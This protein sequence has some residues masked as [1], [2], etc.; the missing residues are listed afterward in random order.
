MVQRYTQ[1]KYGEAEPLLRRALKISKQAL[2]ENH[3]DVAQSLNTLAKVLC[4]EVIVAGVI[5]LDTAQRKGCT[6]TYVG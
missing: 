2:G 1:G 3:P 6:L 5:F 4:D